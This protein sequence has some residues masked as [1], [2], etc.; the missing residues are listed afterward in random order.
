MCGCENN[1]TFP[2]MQYLFYWLV[3]LKWFLSLKGGDR[4]WW[5]WYENLQAFC[6]HCQMGHTVIT[7]FTCQDSLFNNASYWGFPWIVQIRVRWTSA[8]FHP[9]PRHPLASLFA[10]FFLFFLTS[11]SVHIS[12]LCGLHPIV[13]LVRSNNPSCVKDSW[14]GCVF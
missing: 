1:P 6:H 4:W 7:L 11:G 10:H 2:L 9:P 5:F 14:L 3:F 8:D 12:P 13:P